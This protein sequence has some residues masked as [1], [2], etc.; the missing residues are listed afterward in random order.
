MKKYWLL[1]CI[2]L[3][4][5]LSACDSDQRLKAPS[6][7]ADTPDALKAG[8]GVLDSKRGQSNL[9][10]ELYAEALEKDT[11]L[12]NLQD[13]LSALDKRMA[14]V[15]SLYGFYNEKSREYY[16]AANAEALQVQDSLL[17][18]KL[19]GYIEASAKRYDG[20]T[21]DLRQLVGRIDLNAVTLN[22]QQSVLKI[23]TTI[24][25]MEKYQ[26]NELPRD[27][28]F[29]EVIKEQEKLIEKSEAVTH[30]F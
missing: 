21:G 10:D 8:P 2:G 17:R 16:H 15:K 23:V 4:M 3:L 9:V 25:M 11:S 26:R 30:G 24:S 18:V 20:L 19:K 6:P 13:E 22:D 14:D 5:L 27:S 28:S 7:K 29:T 12:K 1:P